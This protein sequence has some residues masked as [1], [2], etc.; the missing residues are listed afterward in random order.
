MA[1]LSPFARRFRFLKLLRASLVLGAL[2]DVAFAVL[3]VV[4]P[5]VLA[6]AFGLPLPGPRFYLW[7]IA[8]LLVMLAA[9][10]V[11]AARDPRRYSAIIRV[12]IGGRLLGALALGTAAVLGPSLAGLWPAAA[13]DA[14]FGLAHALFWLPSRG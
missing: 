8:V 12:A 7:L 2:Y 3:M 11:E 13:A 4:A 5:G 1:D 14:A 9:L 6:S 10:Y